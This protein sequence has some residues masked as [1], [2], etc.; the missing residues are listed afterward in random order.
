FGWLHAH[1]GGWTY[2]FVFLVICLLVQLAAA[3]VACR[4]QLL[5]DVWAPPA[6]GAR[7]VNGPAD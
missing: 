2:P 3:W 1:S 6:R 5:E 4:P 7:A